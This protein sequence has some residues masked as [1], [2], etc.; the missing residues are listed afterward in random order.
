MKR[1]LIIGGYG[2]FGARLSRRLSQAGWRVL[3]AGRRLE[4]A[5]AFCEDLPSAV[6]ICADRNQDI[7]PLLD[8]HQPDL[9]IDAAGPFQDSDY[10]VPNA[11]IKAGVHY[12]DLA[13][14]RGFV[15]D[16]STLDDMAQAAHV[17]IISG[18]SSV[19]ALSGA[20]VRQL[21]TQ[22]TRVSAINMAIS[23]SNRATAGPS[24]AASILSYVGKALPIW[25]GGI[26]QSMTG[27]HMLRQERFNVPGRKTL[28]RLVALSDVPDHTLFP[29]LLEGGPA[30]VF[31]AG[32]EFRFQV[33]AIWLLSWLVKWRVLPSLQGLSGWLRYFQ[34]PTN[35]L[36]SDRS[37]MVVELKGFSGADARVARWTL[38][39]EDGDG[40]EIPTLAAFIL[41]EMIVAGKVVL[42]AHN[43]AG[44]L[45]LAQFK[46]L[47]DG[48]AIYTDTDIKPYIPL[49]QRIMGRSFDTLPKAVRDL[50]T[51][52][53]NG[54]ASGEAIVT[55]GKS[56][57]AALIN[58]IIGFPKAGTHA[59]HATFD[60]HM[61][62]ETW[63]R[64]F[65]GICFSSR[66]HQDGSSI[67]ESFGP[68]SF[69]MRLGGDEMGLTMAMQGW[70][71]F[72]V[73]MPRWLGPTSQ[74][75]EWQDGDAF[76]FDVAIKL[77]VIG[78]LVRYQ[79]R[80]KPV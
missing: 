1:V 5:Q 30:T 63:T 21:K 10:R 17:C 38:I 75:R 77:P 29:A 52:V 15:A 9:V 27:W 50:H 80:L 36:G 23:A 20:V 44:L 72:G 12:L 2:G 33:L 37:G 66:L 69:R 56:A 31:R 61:G 6:P 58:T 3:V 7:A 46:P 40:P 49:Y 18:A 13:D 39:V 22:F 71:A 59:L 79:G 76:C 42:G 11:C 55:R 78:E 74:A 60:E 4:V 68:L 8:Q 35:G 47:F 43:A 25:R 51:L 41:A 28:N 19:P 14:A 65:D 73:P 34:A 70:T 24:V 45:G 54:G 57:T 64:D 32:P 48:L 26:W 16:V 53:G 62:V 67:V